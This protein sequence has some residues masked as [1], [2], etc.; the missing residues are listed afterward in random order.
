MKFIQQQINLW[1][2]A[3]AFFT[4]IP[5]PAST[6]FSQANLNRASRYFPAVGWLIGLICAFSLW[7]GLQWFSIEIAVILSMLV[8]LLLTGCFH[9]DGL[10]D[11]CDGM[12]GGWTVKQKLNIMKDSRIGTYGSAALWVSLSLKFVAL[13]QLIE[14]I[15]ALIVAHPL[16]RVI[17]TVLIRI[18]PYVADTDTSKVKPLAESGSNAD[19]FIAVFSGGLALL[20][21]PS[22]L[23]PLVVVL[24][25]VGLV[26]YL[27][28]RK[29]LN[30]FTGDALGATQQV[31]ELAIYLTLL[32]A[33]A[34]TGD[35][36]QSILKLGVIA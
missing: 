4:R 12:G 23:F 15:L 29:Q 31:S 5:V 2:I 8:S 13:S 9:E 10:A 26:S 16:S 30:G 19:T 3:L 28:L 1:F 21:V 24:L 36:V 7:L 25:C 34:S 6:E 20:L 22:S 33:S 17:P 14:P 18:M 32:A 27:F 11:S 35:I